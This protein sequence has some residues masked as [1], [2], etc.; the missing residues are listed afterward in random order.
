M[1]WNSY[2]PFTYKQRNGFKQLLPIHI[3]NEI[4]TEGERNENLLPED[5]VDQM[6]AL[7]DS[8]TYTYVPSNTIRSPRESILHLLLTSSRRNTNGRKYWICLRKKYPEKTGTA[9]SWLIHPALEKDHETESFF[10]G[11]LYEVYFGR[12][13][14]LIFAGI[15]YQKQIFRTRK[16]VCQY[17]LY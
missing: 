4:K 13:E 12:E 5:F 14:S 17:Q 11:E 3:I 1:Y 15:F 7:V 6:L 2:L 9:E 16:V 8:G 10:C